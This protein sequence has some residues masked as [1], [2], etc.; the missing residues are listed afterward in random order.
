MKGDKAFE[1]FME[2]SRDQ[3]DKIMVLINHDMDNLSSDD[4]I[5]IKAYDVFMNCHD[6]REATR[7]LFREYSI[8]RTFASALLSL[9]GKRYFRT[10]GNLPSA[11]SKGA[12]GGGEEHDSEEEQLISQLQSQLDQC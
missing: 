11:S 5:M 2:E 7:I 4:R 10:Y 3:Y 6:I 9:T 8:V 1:K 12:S